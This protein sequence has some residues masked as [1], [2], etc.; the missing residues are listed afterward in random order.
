VFCTQQLNVHERADPQKFMDSPKVYSD[1]SDK[2]RGIDTEWSLSRV[3]V[4][5]GI[6]KNDNS[7]NTSSFV[8]WRYICVEVC[9][10]EES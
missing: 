3:E 5:R 4:H 1:L 10:F 8:A 6:L 7:E 9:S 2:L